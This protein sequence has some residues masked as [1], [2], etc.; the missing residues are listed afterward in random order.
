MIKK[1]CLDAGHGGKDPGAVNEKLKY[2]ESAA[3]LQIIKRLRDLFPFWYSVKLTR[4]SDDMYVSLTERC[5]ISNSFGADAFISVHLNSFSDKKANGLEVL[6]YTKSGDT[7]KK[8]ATVIH[9]Q[10]I[11][12]TGLRDRGIKLRDNVTVLKKTK[13]PA[14]LVECGFISNDD[15]ARKLFNPE[16]QDKIARAIFTGIQKMNA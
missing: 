9:E 16:F 13:A 8:L 10:L 11:T 6:R 1:I 3:A 5:R 12:A 15:E 7:T 2:N 14:I 4:T